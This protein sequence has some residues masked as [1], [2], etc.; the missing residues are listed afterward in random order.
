MYILAIS[1]YFH[2]SLWGLE[3]FIGPSESYG[4]LFWVKWVIVRIKRSKERK[5]GGKGEEK[6]KGRGESEGGKR[7]KE[8]EGR[9]V[10]KLA[11]ELVYCASFGS[12]LL[13]SA[14]CSSLDSP[15]CSDHRCWGAFCIARSNF[16]S[17]FKW[18]PLSHQ[19][20][21]WSSWTFLHSRGRSPTTVEPDFIFFIAFNLESD[22]VIYVF[23]SCFN[24][25]PVGRG[26]W[27]V[28]ALSLFSWLNSCRVESTWHRVKGH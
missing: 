21:R 25:S 4:I 8:R 9:K 7:E 11:F 18:L 19:P 3:K 1:L 15:K 2:S 16:S 13:I 6:R 12:Y 10:G 22:D 26:I 20:L 28:I 27:E 17:V 24:D 14:H 5:E 23:I